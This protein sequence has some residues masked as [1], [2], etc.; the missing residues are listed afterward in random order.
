MSK[1][2]F[3]FGAGSSVHADGPLNKDW[4]ERIKNNKDNIKD[5]PVAITFLNSLPGFNNLEAL[6]SLI[7]LSII[8]QHNYLPLSASIDYLKSIRAQIINCIVNVANETTKKVEKD[9]LLFDFF[10]KTNLEEGDTLINFN[11][12]LVVDWGLFKTELWNPYLGIKNNLCGYGFGISSLEGPPEKNMLKEKNIATSKINYLKLNGSINWLEHNTLIDLDWNLFDP[13]K[14][15]QT[16]FVYSTPP[17][18]FIIT[19]SFIKIFKE[20]PLRMV[21]LYAHKSVSEASEIYI[22]GYS[23]PKA[24][25]LSRQLLLNSNDSIN[26]ITVIDNL[27]DGCAKSEKREDIIS[28]LSWKREADFWDDKIEIKTQTIEQYVKS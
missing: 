19:P 13:E 11:Y 16:S 18:N 22:S 21:W 14:I 4:I 9:S 12:D 2:V 17:Y 8:E 10:Q 20:M 6:L 3:I 26:K 25:I 7:D 27:S 1:K 28:M 15:S 24:D 5:Y 23:F